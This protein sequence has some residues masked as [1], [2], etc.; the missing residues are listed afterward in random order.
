M[1]WWEARA[2]VRG[3]IIQGSVKACIIQGYNITIVL[4]LVIVVDLLLCLIFKFYHRYIYIGKPSNIQGLVL[5]AVSG[6]H[7]RSKNNPP[8]KRGNYRTCFLVLTV[9]LCC[10]A[11]FQGKIV[12]L[13]TDIFKNQVPQYSLSPP[14]KTVTLLQ[15]VNNKDMEVSRQN[16]TKDE[17]WKT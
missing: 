16:S 3:C 9:C 14:T 15:Q 12:S 5:S 13:H 8:R 7:Q 10:T 2:L 11:V 17:K 4:L 6:I 1:G